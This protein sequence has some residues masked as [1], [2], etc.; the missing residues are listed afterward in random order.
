MSLAYN[1]GI[2]S[3]VAMNVLWSNLSCYP[4]LTSALPVTL[5]NGVTLNSSSMIKDFFE[6]ARLAITQ[7]RTADMV[8]LAN[9]FKLLNSC[10]KS[11]L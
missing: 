2:S 5:S 4:E 6:Q 9:L 11:T 10:N 3:A 8:K 7:N 1:G